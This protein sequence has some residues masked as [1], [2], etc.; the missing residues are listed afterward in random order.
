MIRAKGCIA[1]FLVLV[2]VCMPVFS[3]SSGEAWQDLDELNKI[4]WVSGFKSGART[5][6]YDWS[7]ELKVTAKS[8]KAQIARQKLEA[9]VAKA[10]EPVLNS[11]TEQIIRGMNSLYSDY[12][13]LKIDWG[14]ILIAAAA[15]A[16]G[17]STEDT[18]SFLRS[19]REAAQDTE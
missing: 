3:D 4:L 14:T 13:N 6:A 16:T 9:R 11:S 8:E 7:A 12:R 15:S 1:V 2:L 5:A 17:L 10:Q 18:E 19:M